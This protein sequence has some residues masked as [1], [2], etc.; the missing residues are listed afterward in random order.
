MT[1]E[2][3]IAHV[4][5]EIGQANY[6]TTN[7]AGSHVVVA[8][9]PASA[10][11]ANAG[12]NP[13]AL[14]LSGLGSCTVITLRM[15][16]ERKQWPLGKITADLKITRD[17]E[18]T[19]H[20]ERVLAFEGPLDAEQIARLADIAERTPVTLAVKGGVEVKTRVKE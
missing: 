4:V 5:S 1:T 6:K 18:R 3:L 7:H 12:P 17:A 13:F 9:E 14:L 11:G 19:L 20:I 15:Y 2:S 8:D 10:G 16:A